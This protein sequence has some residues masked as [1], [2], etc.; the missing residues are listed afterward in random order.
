MPRDTQGT[1]VVL[2]GT[3]PDVAPVAR[4]ADGAARTSP[5]FTPAAEALPFCTMDSEMTADVAAA[6][7]LPPLP[8]EL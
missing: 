4:L 3:T 2:Y 8:A 5:A 6:V 1:R 7:E